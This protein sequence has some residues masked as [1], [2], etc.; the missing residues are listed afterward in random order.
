MLGVIRIWFHSEMIL[1]DLSGACWK[2]CG[3]KL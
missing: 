2:Y 1:L 3:T